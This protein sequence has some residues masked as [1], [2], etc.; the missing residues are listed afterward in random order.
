M[1]NYTANIFWIFDIQPSMVARPLS[2]WLKWT[3]DLRPSSQGMFVVVQPSC[4]LPG[5]TKTMNKAIDQGSWRGG[6]RGPQRG[7]QCCARRD[8]SWSALQGK[9][10]VEHP[11]SPIAGQ[12]CR[13]GKAHWST[14]KVRRHGQTH[15]IISYHGQAKGPWTPPDEDA[16]MRC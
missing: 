6:S 9:S 11:P 12:T 15:D 10:S 4:M 13:T 3:L 1:T 2:W 14:Q 5:T 8:S 7:Q 16:E